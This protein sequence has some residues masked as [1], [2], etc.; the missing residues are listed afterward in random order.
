MTLKIKS[1]A[2][3]QQSIKISLVDAILPSSIRFTDFFKL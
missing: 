2:K 1:K 3:K